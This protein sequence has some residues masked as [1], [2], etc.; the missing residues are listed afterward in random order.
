ML[1]RWPGITLTA[2]A[3]PAGISEAVVGIVADTR[4]V[5]AIQGYRAVLAD[6]IR[7]P[8]PLLSTS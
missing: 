4:V 8:V 7:L 3:R 1:D 5:I 2:I 6:K